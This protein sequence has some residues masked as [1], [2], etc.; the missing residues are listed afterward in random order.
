M[1]V[2][3]ID[4]GTT[5]SLCAV[6]HHNQAEI[7]P[8]VFGEYLT[9][10]CVYIKDDKFIVG[11][12][13]REK[14]V[15]EPENCASLFKRTMGTDKKYVLDGKSYSSEELSSFVVKQLIYDAEQYL[16]E[17]VEEVIISVPAYFDAKQREA[18]RR[19]GTLLGVKTERLVNEPSA[20][21]LACHTG[22]SYETFAILDFGGGTLDISIVDCFENVVSILSIAGDNHLGGSDFDRAIALYFMAENKLSLDSLPEDRKMAVL[23][24]AERVKILLG[25]KESAVMY[26]QV[27]GN[28]YETVITRDILKD[29]CMPVLEKMK[30]VIL[31]AVQGSGMRPSDLDSM[32]LVGG[33]CCMPLVQEYLEELLNL[34]ILAGKEMEKLVAEGLAIYTGIHE[35]NAEVKDL[36]LTDIC[37]FSLCTSVYNEVDAQKSLSRVVISRNTILPV[38]KT[39]NLCALKEKQKEIH[40]HVYQGENMYAKDNLLL[41]EIIIPIPTNHKGQE[42]FELTYSYDIN[43]MLFVEVRILSTNEVYSYQIGDTHTLEKVRNRQAIESIERV[44]L[45]LSRQADFDAVIE[46]MNRLYKEMHEEERESFQAF[47]QQFVREFRSLNNIRKKMELVDKVNEMMD[48]YEQERTFVEEELFSNEEDGNQGGGFYA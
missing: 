36:V 43:S 4:L 35:R 5:N 20:A 33:S 28:Q 14:S 27:N 39:V 46:R 37:P 47:A 32:I 19:I 16:G 42:E 26:L 9:P 38:T 34:D 29:I 24:E 31:E 1:A 48:H 12:I 15:L 23:R 41:G 13:A 3:G 44:S 30:P 45:Q 6:Y 7:I 10:S 18:T 40:I 22:D 8:N 11:K 2:I 17:K 25:E 21:A